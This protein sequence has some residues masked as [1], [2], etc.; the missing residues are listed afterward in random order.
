MDECDEEL[1]KIKKVGKDIKNLTHKSEQ[2]EEMI[3]DYTSREESLSKQISGGQ[4]RLFRLQ[5]S[6]ESKRHAAQMA[7]EQV[8]NQKLGVL[9]AHSRDKA[10]MSSIR[11]LRT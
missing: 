4:E 5:K 10:L 6:F 1:G 9:R 8:Q 3:H 7:Y 2:L 11:P